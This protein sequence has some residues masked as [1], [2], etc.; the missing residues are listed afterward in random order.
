MSQVY[1][2]LAFKIR[3]IELVATTGEIVGHRPALPS[4]WT[5]W[6]NSLGMRP[7]CH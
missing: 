1:C 3:R 4:I 2:C 5:T 7:K 6:P